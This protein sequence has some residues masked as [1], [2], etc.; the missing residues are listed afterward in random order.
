AH[1]DTP[2]VLDL[3]RRRQHMCETCGKCYTSMYFLRDHL[4]THTGTKPYQCSVCP[5]RFTSRVNLRTHED[6]HAPPKRECSYCGKKYTYIVTC[7]II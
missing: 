3:K 7:A 6:W 5:A 2:Y 4:N 1:P